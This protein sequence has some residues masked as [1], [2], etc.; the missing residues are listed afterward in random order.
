MTLGPIDP[1]NPSARVERQFFSITRW[2][3]LIATTI[4]L[5]AAIIAGAG[6]GLKLFN[7]PD[8]HIRTPTTSYDDFR[9]TAETSRQ[10]NAPENMD[11]TLNEKQAA[12]ARASAEAEFEKR[13]KPYLDAIV[14]S[15]SAYGTKT[16]QAKP[17]AQSIGDYIRQWMQE[18][19]KYGPDDLAWKYAEGLSIAARDLASD[20]DRLA[21]LDVSDPGRVRWDSFIEWYSK[22]YVQ[23]MRTELQRI[24]DEKMSALSSVAEAPR[25]FYAAV[26]AFG[27]FV[28]GTILLVLL[29]IEWNTRTVD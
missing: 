4:A 10:N 26:I 5:A 25:Y 22:S 23:Q 11:T 17:S 21:K 24:D 7:A 20:G 14:A 1:V 16:A 19:E 2:F 18:I 6:G 29:R 15:L 12:A 9:K 3:V 8:T 13:L 28:L 27:I